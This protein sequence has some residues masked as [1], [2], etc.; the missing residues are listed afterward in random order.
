M[1]HDFK[2]SKLDST[3]CSVCDTV[4]SEHKC[5]ICGFPRIEKFM[6]ILFCD[7]C[8]Q[9]EIEAQS[10]LRATEQLRLADLAEKNRQELEQRKTLTQPDSTIQVSSDIFNAKIATIEEWRKAIDEDNSVENKHFELSKRMETRFLHLKQV[11]TDAQLA[12]KDAQNEQRAIQSYYNELAKKLK[13]EEREKIKIQDVQYH[14]P[15]KPTK[16]VSAPK[17]KVFDRAS[18][19]QAA[20]E[21]GIPEML[22]QLTCT[23]RNVTAVEA[24]RI[25]RESTSSKSN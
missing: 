24:V 9:K 7:P 10:E 21:S 3:K 1:I 22:I 12:L 4:E 16:K 13:A 25:I 18:V 19:K 17:V 6:G 15:E 20:S 5:Q 11:I 2:P 8:K 14:P 23:A